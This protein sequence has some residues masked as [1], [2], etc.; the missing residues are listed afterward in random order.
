M[1]KVFITC[2]IIISLIISVIPVS[3][4]EVADTVLLGDVTQDDVI[5]IDDA[6]YSLRCASG[7]EYISDDTLMYTDLD[8]DGTVSTED[9]R[10]ILRIAAGISEEQVLKFTDWVVTIEPTCTKEGKAVS[11]SLQ[12]NYTREKVLPKISH[13]MTEAT[14]TT[15]GYCTECFDYFYP[16]KGH[17]ES[18]WIMDSPITATSAGITHKECTTCHEILETTI[19]PVI[20]FEKGYTTFGASVN[21]LVNIFGEPTE[22]LTDNTKS[23]SSVK[24]YVYANDYSKLTIFTVIDELGLAGVYSLDPSMKIIT[25]KTINFDNVSSIYNLDGVY[26][27][28]YVDK[29]GTGEVYA[30]HAT[31]CKETTKMYETTDFRSSEK[32]NFHMLNA[33]RAINNLQPLKYSKPVADV[34]LS[35]SKNMAEYNFF[36]HKDP[37]GQSGYTRLIAAGIQFNGCGEN[38]AAG[39]AM[40]P[41]DFNNSWYNSSG[42]RT[43][44]L[45]S[46]FTEVGIGFAY[47]AT[48]DYPYYGTQNYIN[49]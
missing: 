18:E 26:Y 8:F 15:S 12:G 43:L 9:A 7:L 5:S 1:K 41:Y 6:V 30:F 14:C 11:H 49:Y 10:K 37:F 17:T 4:T 31:T 33:C 28:A 40:S 38:I 44:M 29:L 2:L 24:Y 16:P 20:S 47:S 39:H 36:N 3:A 21:D 42:H 22:I 25:T 23:Y 35:H 32:L 34:A 45:S 46:S 19:V 27:E 13:K 48:A